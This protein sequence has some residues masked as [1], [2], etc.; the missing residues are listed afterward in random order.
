[1]NSGC[2]TVARFHGSLLRRAQ[3]LRLLFDGAI[4]VHGP[5]GVVLRSPTPKAVI[6]QRV[7]TRSVRVSP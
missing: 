2:T 3:M 5:K 4:E 7:I 1:M 6:R